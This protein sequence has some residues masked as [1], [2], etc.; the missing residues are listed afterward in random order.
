MRLLP[1]LLLASLACRN[2]A[3]SDDPKDVVTDDP[4]DT[5]AVDADGDGWAASEDCD[6]TDAS[7]F[8]AA[9]ELCNGVDDDCDGDLDEGA[10]DLYFADADGDG[11]G[12]DADTVVSCEVLD[13]HVAR[14]GDCDDAVAARNPDATE[15][16]DGFDDDCDGEVDEGLL[17]EVFADRDGDG[18]GDA[19]V[20]QL[21]CEAGAGWADAA[22]DCDDTDADTFPDA[23]E[24]CDDRDNDCDGD[25]DEALSLTWYADADGDGFGALGTALDTCDPPPGW[26]AD[27]TDCDDLDPGAFPGQV[28]ACDG[29]DNDCDVDEGLLQT[30]WADG[31][32]DGF[33]GGVTAEAC[34]VP[35]GFVDRSG[36]CDDAVAAVSPNATELCDG[37]DNDCDGDRDES[38]AAD[39]PAWYPDHDGDGFGGGAAVVQCEAPAGHVADASDCDDAVVA[40]NPDAV[41]VCDG[42]DNDC[43]TETDEPTAVDAGTWYADSDGDGFGAAASATVA[44]EA[45]QGFVA[46][47]TDCDD[48]DDRSNPG[49]P[50][51]CDGVDNDC[52]VDVDEGLRST[53]FVDADADGWGD[54][55]VTVEACSVPAGFA[56][57]SG[58]CD[59]ADDGRNPD[60]DE[61]CNAADDDCDGVS[62]E[63]FA[64]S[65]FFADA[66]GDG[67]GSTTAAGQSCLVPPGFVGDGSDCDDLDPAVNA[68]ATEVCNGVDYNCDGS[69]DEGLATTAYHADADGDGFGDVEVAGASCRVPAGFVT[70]DSDCDDLDPGVNVSA[71]EVCNGLDDNCDGAADE[72]LPTTVSYAD[73]DGDGF[74]D[75]VAAITSCQVPPGFVADDT[76][77]DDLDPD[78][79]PA[80]LEVCNGVDDDCD[81]LVDPGLTTTFYADADGDGDGTDLLALEACGQPPGFVAGAGD[82][83]DGDADVGPSALEVCNGIDDDCDGQVD[84]GLTGTFYADGDGDGVGNDALSTVACSAP[85]GFVA[86]PGDCDDGDAAIRPGA[87]EVCNGADDDCDGDTDGG[88]TSVFHRDADGDGYGDGGVTLEACVQPA[89]HVADA[90]DCDDSSAATF[91][92][93]AESCDGEDN[94][95]DGVVDNDATDAVPGFVDAD[96]DGFGDADNV[97]DACPDADG[98]V[99]V[100]GDCDDADDAIGVCGSCQQ[101][102]SAGGSV[103]DGVYLLDPCGTGTPTEYWCDMTTGGGGWTV[104][105]WQD[106]NATTSMGVS[107]WGMVGADQWSKDLACLER[108]EVLVFNRTHGL[109]HQQSYASDV[110]DFTATNFAFG[111]PG[112]AFKHGTYGPSSSQI[113][114]GCVD[115]S[116]NGGVNP[117]FA[118]DSDWQQ[119]AKGHLADYAGEYCAGARLDF[120][121]AWSNGSTCSFRG[122]LYTWGYA[123][124]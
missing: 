113:M 64:V 13:G 30:F 32:G 111:T 59:D 7:V 85:T 123:I 73:V 94:D 21:A 63:G 122:E 83:D 78:V 56:T 48:G 61:V 8:P 74:G 100:P 45:P 6:D 93:A 18:V 89:G 39:A 41:E 22:G 109:S 19:A 23:A 82:C 14:G 49:E 24:R 101:I 33:G 87:T 66:D 53:F 112:T 115:Y 52:D 58:D 1:L 31:D 76:D 79:N 120:T 34:E 4:V 95:C 37:T 5:D 81:T 68:A 62:D 2:D 110:W 20:S 72:G 55:R 71:A 57:V 91:P 84:P 12:A 98:V 65:D 97:V 25:V 38:D 54:D 43:D 36:D 116:Y 28:E 119:G 35:A 3:T 46:D 70:D 90:T 29:V 27:A 17:V 80:S 11:W 16:C 92:G 47:A 88:L 77:C 40:V 44:C 26:V 117:Q 124:R 96:G 50:E 121:W 51:V 15:V 106:A 99:D 42:V 86:T 107:D 9:E 104:A 67:F 118:C 10:G 60:A 69:A 108:S 105:G 75:A 114:M 103:G 102:L